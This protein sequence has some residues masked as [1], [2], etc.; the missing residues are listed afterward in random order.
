MRRY[1]RRIVEVWPWQSSF[2]TNICHAGS[3]AVMAVTETNSKTSSQ[4]FPLSSTIYIQT[5]DQLTSRLVLN[6]LP[7]N[8][9]ELRLRVV[10]AGSINMAVL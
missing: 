8:N 6:K 5:A 10:T 7:M 4:K 9:T 1:V 2:F 3:V